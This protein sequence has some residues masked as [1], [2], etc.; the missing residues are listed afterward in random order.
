MAA[1]RVFI[2]SIN[3]VTNFTFFHTWTCQKLHFSSRVNSKSISA[4][5]WS[6]CRSTQEKNWLK[7]F[8]MS[9]A[10]VWEIAKARANKV[11]S[12]TTC[13]KVQTSIIC[14]V[15]AS[16]AWIE[17]RT[18]KSN[19]TMF[20]VQATTQRSTPSNYKLPIKNSSPLSQYYS[21]AQFLM[22]K[23]LRVCQTFP[24]TTMQ[25]KHLPLLRI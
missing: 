19:I 18:L 11:L 15:R 10:P 12:N 5:S 20:L 24:P 25:Q 16:R 13:A 2:C 23:S 6:R 22:I 8:R 14:F 9:A 4:H 17:L 7:W 21:A 1:V 3:S